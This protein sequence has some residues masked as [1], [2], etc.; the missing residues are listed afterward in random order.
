MNSSSSFMSSTRSRLS[1]RGET[2][3]T[4]GCGP[5][6]GGD[7]HEG[8]LCERWMFS[9][10]CSRRATT[11]PDA[12]SFLFRHAASSSGKELMKRCMCWSRARSCCRV[13][14]S[15]CREVG[16]VTCTGQYPA[17][18]RPVPE[19]SP[20]A[21]PRPER[22]PRRSSAGP[23][24]AEWCRSDSASGRWD[25]SACRAAGNGRPQ[26]Q[27]TCARAPFS[28]VTAE[29]RPFPSL[30][31]AVSCRTRS[32]SMRCIC[33]GSRSASRFSSTSSSRFFSSRRSCV[34]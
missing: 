30:M 25:V 14:A 19:S 32:R 7:T 8:R 21:P 28:A 24:A 10:M 11:M 17:R 5:W 22:P 2:G 23:L 13:G 34:A 33:F 3:K 16:S 6:R 27:P 29:S 9:P 4:R 31:N 12:F 1:L 20:P 26:V 15:P 18:P